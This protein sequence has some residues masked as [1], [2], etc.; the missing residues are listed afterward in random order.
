MSQLES[1]ANELSG[2]IDEVKAIES[3]FRRTRDSITLTSDD[4]TTFRALLTDV[5]S[6]YEAGF[7][8]NNKF[9]RELANWVNQY[10]GGMSGGPSL[11][12][13]QGSHKLMASALKQMGRLQAAAATAPPQPPKS[14]RPPYVSVS[15]LEELRVL[16]K[17]RWDLTRL[18]RMVEEL[19]DAY[20]RGNFVTVT[21]LVRAIK[22]H[23]PPVFSSTNFAGVFN[24]SSK[25]VKGNLE[26]LENSLKHIADGQ[27]HSHIRTSEVLPTDV[28][29]DFRNDL[30]VLLGEVVRLIK[31]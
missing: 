15:R 1:L 10:S 26:R 31:V 20:E 12:A 25:S 9:A 14:I 29:V 22:D 21:M 7:G 5:M 6:I 13:V 19:N 24:S 18:I 8:P 4:E 2:I 16:P 23:V 27:L 11:V 17:A 30:D 28:Q 3:R